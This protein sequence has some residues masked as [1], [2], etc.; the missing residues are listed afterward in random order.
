[1]PFDVDLAC[2]TA[3]VAIRRETEDALR[4]VESNIDRDIYHLVARINLQRYARMTLDEAFGRELLSVRY[5]HD[6][7]ALVP[8]G[9]K[10]TV[11]KWTDLRNLI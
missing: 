1:M 11:Y 5:G 9:E 2:D 7:S 6:P 8:S 10:P 3:I 4:R